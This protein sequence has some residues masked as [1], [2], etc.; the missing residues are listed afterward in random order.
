MK[1]VLTAAALAFLIASPVLAEGGW[2]NGQMSAR[3][4]DR[5]GSHS[6]AP[7]QNERDGQRWDPNYYN[8]NDPNNR[9]Q[10]RHAAEHDK[11]GLD[12]R[13]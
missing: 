2:S 13:Q 8:D 5:G 12:V 10:S 11:G 9:A 4:G 1:S 7:S 6:P 3:D